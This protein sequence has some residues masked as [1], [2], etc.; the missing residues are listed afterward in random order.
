MS[1]RGYSREYGARPLRRIIQEQLQD[2]ISDQLLQVD[3]ML[4]GGRFVVD[5][6]PA[7]GEGDEM[8]Q[9]FDIFLE[10][11]GEEPVLTEEDDW[12]SGVPEELF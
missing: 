2:P 6:E 10:H 5:V 3:D 9:E 4:P 1:R 11:E 7:M 8:E 12:N